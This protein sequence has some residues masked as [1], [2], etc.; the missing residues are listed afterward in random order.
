M[1]HFPAKNSAW[2]DQ[3]GGSPRPWRKRGYPLT[4]S[5]FVATQKVNAVLPRWCR[6][7]LNV[8]SNPA[9]LGTVPQAKA[10]AGHAGPAG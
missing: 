10:G 3:G 5:A 7:R 2:Q 8:R 9:R 1:A 4:R 6:C